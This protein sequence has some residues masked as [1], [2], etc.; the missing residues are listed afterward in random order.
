M[1]DLIRRSGASASRAHDRC[2]GVLSRGETLSVPWNAASYSLVVADDMDITG[3]LTDAAT[4]P[5]A[6]AR[7]LDDSALSAEGLYDLDS[8]TRSLLRQASDGGVPDD[9][10]GVLLLRATHDAI[11]YHLAF[12]EDGRCTVEP[13]LQLP[14]GET[15]PPKVEVQPQEVVDRWRALR[16][17]STSPVWRSRLGHLLVASGRLAGK[18]K[19]DLASETITLAARV[20]VL[21]SGRSN[22]NDPNDARSVA[23]AA[24]R[25]PGL[26]QVRPAD[27]ASVLRL[28]AKRNSQLSSTRTRTACRLHALLAELVEG[29]SAKKLKAHEAER[30]LASPTTPVPAARHALALEHLEDLRRVDAQIAASKR[31]IIEAVNASGTTVTELVGV[32]PVVAAMVIGYTA[33]WGAF[34]AAPTTPPPRAPPPSRCP[35]AVA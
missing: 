3:A 19:V 4:A 17:A 35:P 10:P 7:L 20:R 2:D 30:L 18:D 13:Y 6:V 9:A 29:G 25:A 8:A 27:H 24:L 34:P 21:G 16:D 1:R 26:G 15:R 28:L 5:G 14:D 32:G 33:R 31:R 23:I 12:D 11:T 22:K